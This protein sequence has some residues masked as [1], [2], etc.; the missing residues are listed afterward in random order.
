VN[1]EKGMIVVELGV[2]V[3]LRGMSGNGRKSSRSVS[4]CLKYNERDC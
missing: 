4:K 2:L 1:R 3:I